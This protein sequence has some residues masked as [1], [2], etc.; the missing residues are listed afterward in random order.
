MTNTYNYKFNSTTGDAVFFDIAGN[1]ILNIN[2]ES[3]GN[4]LAIAKA[5]YRAEASGR[6]NGLNIAKNGIINELRSMDTYTHI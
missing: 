2:C 3:F 4:A 5:L 6:K 1:E